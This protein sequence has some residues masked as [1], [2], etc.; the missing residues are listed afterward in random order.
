MS[1][2]W[3]W[4][5][6][7]A[8]ALG[9]GLTW[10]FWTGPLQQAA[11]EVTHD[12]YT[13]PMHPEVISDKPGEC[14]ICGMRLV[15]KEGLSSAVQS[16]PRPSG[17][18]LPQAAEPNEVALSPQQQ[19]LAN[20]ATT[21]VT[22]R[23]LSESILAAGRIMPDE[24]RL[25]TVPAW[26]DG[27]ID[28]LYVNTTGQWVAKGQRIASLYSPD[29]VASQQEYLLALKGYRE[30]QR[31]PY[32]E[33]REGAKALLEASRQRLR[34]WGIDESQI[35]AVA[36]TGKAQLGVTVSSP[37]SGVVTK[38]YVTEGQYVTK[39]QPLFDLA[40]LSRIWVEADVPESK[41]GS[42][43]IGAPAAVTAVG[44]PD[45]Q[46]QGTV[47]FVQPALNP[48]SRTLQVRIELA[49][50]GVL[51]KPNMFVQAKVHAPSARAV[52]VPASAVIDT[53]QRQVVWVEKSPGRY[54]P[55]DVKLSARA[56]DFY[57]VVSGLVAGESVVTQGGFLI[58]AT[59]QLR[60][61]GTGHEGHG[62]AAL[63]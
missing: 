62:E 57:P 29:V 52:A 37:D 28:R 3:L 15:K 21:K 10:A 13:C 17:G 22:V 44:Y 36:G 60:S 24:R 56:G 38:R 19:V 4:V 46:W 39:G 11:H 55:R 8:L 6:A 49:N 61:G 26:I 63:D 41:M 33:V 31:S 1:R 47:A 16:A 27:R 45:R 12:V 7:L 48:E 25:S 59:A 34:L 58:D 43:E 30:A 23:S 14:P 18:G 5:A 9:A 50:P 20:V 53:G 35:K 54:V 40:D 42:V 51:L 2:K 32:E